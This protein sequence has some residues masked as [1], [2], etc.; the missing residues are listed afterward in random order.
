MSHHL[1]EIHAILTDLLTLINERTLSDDIYLLLLELESRVS[2]EMTPYSQEDLSTRLDQSFE[3]LC[4]AIDNKQR[5]MSLVIPEIT[6][7]K[8]IIDQTY[9]SVIV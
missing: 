7:M 6:Q 4:R 8:S 2:F 5:V 1:C 3:V 9:F